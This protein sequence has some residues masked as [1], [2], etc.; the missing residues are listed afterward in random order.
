MA[1]LPRTVLQ[2]ACTLAMICT[3]LSNHLVAG[4]ITRLDS[5]AGRFGKPVLPGETLTIIG[6]GSEDEK[7]V[8]F[9]VFNAHGKA[10]FRDGVF[11]IKK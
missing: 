3:S 6:Y 5:I 7:T 2:G 10:A 4:D 1:G 9:A 11:T 8:P